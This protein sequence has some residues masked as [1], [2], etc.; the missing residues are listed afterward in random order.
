M[1]Q[2]TERQRQ[3]LR[4]ALGLNIADEPYRNWFASGAKDLPDWEA[5]VAA[6]LAKRAKRTLYEN[7][8]VT[9]DGRAAVFPFPQ[10]N[11]SE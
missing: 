1:N 6:G 4:H 5:L 3:L 8:Q 2:I 9:D 7:F 10:E 11:A